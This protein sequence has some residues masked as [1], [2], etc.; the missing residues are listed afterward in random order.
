MEEV[1]ILE[2]ALARKKLQEEMIKAV[3]KKNNVTEEQARLMLMRTG[4]NL[5]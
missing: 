4:V 2:K 5:S 3:M 1:K